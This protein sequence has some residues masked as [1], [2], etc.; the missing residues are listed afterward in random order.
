MK[1]RKETLDYVSMFL[2]TVE[3][4]LLKGLQLGQLVFP[5]FGDEMQQYFMREILFR[6]YLLVVVKITLNQV[7]Y[8]IF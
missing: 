2:F 4:F 7:K 1:E 8:I 5:G 6:K 3:K